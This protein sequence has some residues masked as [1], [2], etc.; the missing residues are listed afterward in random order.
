MNIR[1]AA[2][3]LQATYLQAQIDCVSTRSQKT[4]AQIADAYIACLDALAKAHAYISGAEDAD[5]MAEVL[6]AIEEAMG[7]EGQS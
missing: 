6:E 1:D 3:E 5:D 2:A 7:T 4:A